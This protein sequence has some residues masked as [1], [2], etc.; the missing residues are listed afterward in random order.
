MNFS[1]LSWAVGHIKPQSLEGT[2]CIKPQ[3]GSDLS[4]SVM[5]SKPFS[6]FNCEIISYLKPAV[7][8]S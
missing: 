5:I 6:G 8:T 7:G 2:V 1:T 4:T 3:T